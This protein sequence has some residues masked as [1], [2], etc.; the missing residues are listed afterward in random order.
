MNGQLRVMGF[1]GAD[2]SVDPRMLVALS[3]QYGWLE[4]GVIFRPDKQGEPRYASP[5]WVERLA[6][7]RRASGEAPVRLAAHLCST[8][9]DEVLREDATF[10]QELR[11]L[12][13]A[14]VQIN[15]TAINGVDMSLVS[16]PGASAKLLAVINA[17]PEVEFILQRNAQT[18]PLLDPILAK[19]TPPNVSVL[20]DESMGT[21]VLSPF[22]PPLAGVRCGFAGGLGPA[23]IE[24][25][26]R[27]L[28]VDGSSFWVDMESSLRTRTEDG[29]DVFDVSKCF[30]CAMVAVELGLQS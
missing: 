13:F 23:N 1:C 14:R 11:G 21:G 5:A 9:V 22:P 27:A 16:A 12:G 25:T 15:A 20:F 6:A 10:L 17:V 29:T 30:A 26:L 28:L 4:W 18:L 2:D 24:E 8:R 19:G 7:A 3:R